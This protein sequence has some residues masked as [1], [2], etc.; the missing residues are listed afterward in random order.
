MGS[1]EAKTLLIY[2]GCLINKDLLLRQLLA[3]VTLKF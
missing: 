3:N 1:R 2:L